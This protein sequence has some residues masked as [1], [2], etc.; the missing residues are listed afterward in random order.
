MEYRSFLSKLITR[1]SM[2]NQ[3][4]SR[5]LLKS[6]MYNYKSIKGVRKTYSVKYGILKKRNER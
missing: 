2:E 5:C 1:Q 3:N 4:N 6:M